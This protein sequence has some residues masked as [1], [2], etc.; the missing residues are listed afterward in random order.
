MLFANQ[1]TLEARILKAHAS[2]WS[3]TRQVRSAAS[4]P[5]DKTTAVECRPAG[6]L[7][8]GVGGTPAFFINGI[9]L[10]GRA[11][12]RRVQEASSTRSWPASDGGPRAH[13]L[14]GHVPLDEA[15]RLWPLLSPSVGVVKVGLLLFPEHGPAGFVRSGSW[16]AA[17]FLDLKR[18]T[19]RT[20]SRAR[21]PPRAAGSDL[22]PCSCLGWGG[23]DPG[24]GAGAARGAERAGVPPPRSSLYRAD[25][26]GCAGDGSRF[27]R[28][29]AE[30]AKA[31]A[32]AREA[33]A[34]DLVAPAQGAAEMWRRFPDHF[35]CT[36]GIR[37]V[38]AAWGGGPV[39]DSGRSDPRGRKA[40]GRRPS[41]RYAYSAAWRG[42][43]RRPPPCG[44]EAASV[45]PVDGSR[46]LWSAGELHP[47]CWTGR[48]ARA[49]RDGA[50]PRPGAPPPDLRVPGSSAW[51]R[52]NHL[53][54]GPAYAPTRP[55]GRRAGGRACLEAA[56]R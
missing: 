25:L 33:G 20:R 44:R 16:G 49:G 42:G 43:A 55:P 32:V 45:R 9:M 4:T 15:R 38:G 41:S 8:A 39:G 27:G 56:G 30:M 12:H 14:G 28:S 17:V 40:P 37:P 50:A 11:A 35:L 47:L 19:S 54:R 18:T 34:G 10:Y 52:T 23:A 51:G 3:W 13:R 53:E 26:V 24:G 22:P 48:P 21:R 36:P 31:P 6:R 5:G 29:A 1:K 7:A 46:E 2:E